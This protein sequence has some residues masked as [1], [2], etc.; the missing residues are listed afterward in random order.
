LAPSSSASRNKIPKRRLTDLEV[1]Y[2]NDP[3]DSSYRLAL[4]PDLDA[5][6]D[7]LDYDV[8]ADLD[9]LLN[10]DGND[11]EP[12]GKRIKVTE[13]AWARYDIPRDKLPQVLQP[14]A[15]PKIQEIRSRRWD[16]KEETQSQ[17][18]QIEQSDDGYDNDDRGLDQEN[19]PGD[20]IEVSWSYGHSQ[21]SGD[22]IKG[23]NGKLSTITEEEEEEE[24]RTV[25][26]QIG[27]GDEVR[28]QKNWVEEGVFGD[29]G[30]LGFK[31]WRDRY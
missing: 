10:L 27:N 13:G 4:S 1:R 12:V 28:G 16:G 15:R 24:Q 6:A 3:T 31:I 2:D 19:D 9:D 11:D 14:R 23:G 8:D 18:S 30:E 5:D 22:G 25:G 17:V 7:E 20:D 29:G 26:I 21:Q